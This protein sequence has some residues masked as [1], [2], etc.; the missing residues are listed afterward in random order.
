MSALAIIASLAAQ[1]AAPPTT[2]TGQ[3]GT[4]TAVP[5]QHR[6]IINYIDLEGGAGYS[7]N[8]QHQF[9][10]SRGAGY[11]HL[12]VHGF[13]TRVSER[14]TTVLSAFAQTLFYTNDYGVQESVDLS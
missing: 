9:C 7:T 6:G 8:P 3:P 1:A 11:G 4:D 13:H 12:A 2:G 10:D 5:E 14:S